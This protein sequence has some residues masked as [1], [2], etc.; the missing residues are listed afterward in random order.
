MAANGKTCPLLEN[1]RK[2]D[3]LYYY[4]CYKF[5]IHY[6][7]PQLFTQTRPNPSDFVQNEVRMKLEVVA[8]QNFT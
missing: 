7:C 4:A 3:A 1:P 2:K 6:I 5:I 8:L